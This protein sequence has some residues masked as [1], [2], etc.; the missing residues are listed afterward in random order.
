MENKYTGAQGRSGLDH[1]AHIKGPK[2]DTMAQ[3]V[4]GLDRSAPPDLQLLLK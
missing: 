4:T 2:G 1:F 3:V